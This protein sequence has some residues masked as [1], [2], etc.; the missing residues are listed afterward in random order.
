MKIE[1][2]GRGVAPKAVTLRC[3]SCGK[4]GTFEKVDIQDIHVG[5]TWFGQRRCPNTDCHEHLFF[6]QDSGGLVATYPPQR[7]D[8]EKTGIPANVLQAFEEAITCHA[9]Q[10]YV[11]SA[12]MIRKTLEEICQDRSATGDNLKKRIS[13]LGSQ[14]IIPKELLEGMDELR[15][16][17]NDAAHVEAR[18]FREIGQDEIN[19]SI[20][21]AKEILKAVYQYEELLKKLKDLKAVSGKTNTT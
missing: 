20:E 19:V 7:I 6:I 14:I 10:C 3:P 5:S 8:F 2:A 18:V 12:I 15:L 4:H 9:I 21:F 1:G 17:G 11:A 16:F 13:A